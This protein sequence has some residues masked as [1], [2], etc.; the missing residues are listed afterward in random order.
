M[1]DL[2]DGS[3]GSGNAIMVLGRGRDARQRLDD[4][5]GDSGQKD[6][7]WRGPINSERRATLIIAWAGISFSLL[8]LAAILSAI[9]ELGEVDKTPAI[10]KLFAAAALLLP[11]LALMKSKSRTAAMALLAFALVALAVSLLIA[12]Q[13]GLDRKW[14]GL[15]VGAVISLFWAMI[16][17]LTWRALKAT[18]ALRRIVREGP[19]AASIAATFE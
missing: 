1:L 15:T 7:F 18:A 17:L 19:V 10:F 14:D 4:I 11:S 6:Y 13:I 8:G 2:D 3:A 9:G 16:A 5:A 12:A